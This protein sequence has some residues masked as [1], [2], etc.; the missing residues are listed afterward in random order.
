MD[1]NFDTFQKE[2]RWTT[3]ILIDDKSVLAPPRFFEGIQRVASCST[4]KHP[5]VPS[6][7]DSPVPL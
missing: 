2:L 7:E 1:W 5:L 4:L 3:Q 6:P